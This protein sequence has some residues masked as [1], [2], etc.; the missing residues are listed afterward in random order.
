MRI[1]ITG[2]AGF[3]GFH[4]SKALLDRGDEVV[5]VDNLNDY[6]DVGLKNARLSILKEY[7]SFEFLKI[8]IS[9]P[10]IKKA[11]AGIDKICHLAAQAG[12]RYSLVNPMA[13]ATSN[14]SGTL[15][16]LE[17]ARQN[18]V[19][20]IV[21]ASTSSVYAGGTMPFTEDQPACAPLTV[22]AASKRGSELLAHSYHSLF[23]LNITMLRFFTVYGPW[24]RPDMA[25][26]KF[27]KNI[28]ADKPIDVYNKGDMERDF[29][30]VHD[31]VSGFLLAIDKPLGFSII[32]LGAGSPVK[33]M[34][35]I[36]I[37]ED[38]LGKKAKLN[39]MGM[40]K[41]DVKK[42]AA[43][44]SLAKELLGYRPKVDIKTGVE[45]FID[46]YKDYVS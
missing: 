23:K 37:I 40:Q 43:D 2:C 1:L 15:N 24:G 28:L 36:H 10:D 14:F 5:G 42:T 31:I 33:L 7:D 32:N 41:G 22:Y 45:E 34:D 4:L 39:L 20:D 17:L 19:K 16:I 30:N 12:V 21:A 29:T 35:F 8:D 38:K 3:I 18:K 26:F 46:W 6:Y 27:V 11:F 9:S 44:I 25:L 13:Y